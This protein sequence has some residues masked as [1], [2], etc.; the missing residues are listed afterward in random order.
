MMHSSSLN[1]RINRLHERALGIIYNDHKSNFNELLKEDGSVT[2]HERN[3]Q[4]LA[5]E[6]FKFNN[7]LSPA[8]MN[9]VFNRNTNV[10]Y[11][12]RGC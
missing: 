9:E 8:I 5:I 12:L 7:G 1:S 6:I 3:L 10:N 2:V 4:F 11:N